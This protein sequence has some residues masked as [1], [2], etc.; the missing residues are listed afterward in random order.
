MKKKGEGRAAVE[1]DKVEEEEWSRKRRIQ[2]WKRNG[3]GRGGCSGGG[4]ME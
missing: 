3:V 2:W 1:E 4:R